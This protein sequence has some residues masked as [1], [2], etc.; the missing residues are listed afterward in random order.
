MSVKKLSLLVMSSLVA[1]GC[2]AIPAK[3]G[4]RSIKQPDGTTVKVSLRG[5]ETNHMYINQAG[6]RMI[7]NADGMLVAASADDLVSIKKKE[8][9]RRAKRNMPIRRAASENTTQVPHVNSPRI[10][11]LL[12]QYSDYKF[13]DAD[14]LTTFRSFFS[15][16]E[17]SAHQYFADQS[18]NKFT[19]QFDVYGPVTLTGKRADY[20]G[21]DSQGYDIGVGKMVGQAC[22]AMD[23]QVDFSLYDNDGDGECDVVIVLYAGDGEASSYD[24]DAEDS[25]WPCQ[26]DLASSEFGKSLKLDGTKVNLFA[27][28]NELYGSD[29]KKIDGIGT[30]C[31]EFS[32]CLGLPDFYDTQYGPHFG[33]AH[34]SLMDYG[35]YN[36]DGFTP[37]G[38][39]A[40]EKDFMGWIEI[41]E[42]KEN[43]FYTLTPMNLK[44]EET[45]MAVRITNNSDKNEYYIL[46][47]RAKQGWDKFMPAEG[48]L[49]THFTYSASAWNNNTVNDYDLQRA[50]IIPADNSLKLDTEVVWGETYYYINDDDVL[51]DLWPQSY[52]TELT[53]TSVP[54][55]KVNTGKFMSK[56]IT[57]IVRNADGTVSFWAMKKP[58]PQVEMPTNLRH[59]IL[60][61]TTV[62]FTWES[63]D[64]NIS[65]YTLE[66]AE[67]VE[68]PYTL[69]DDVDFSNSD[70]TSSGYTAVED[71]ALRFGSNKQQG[72]LTSGVYTTEEDHDNVS[73]VFRAKSYGS[74]ASSV[75]V[76]LLDASSKELATQT[77]EL[78]DA[79]KDYTL[80]F[81]VAGNTKFKVRFE[82]VAL[83]KRFY[84]STAQIYSGDYSDAADT[85]RKKTPLKM[86]F[87]NITDNHYTVTG[88]N[89]E[90]L[91]TYRVM[92]HPLDAETYD[93][94][95]W[96]EKAFID[97]A[98]SVDTVNANV[99]K[100]VRWFTI[101]GEALN[102]K[103]TVPGLYIKV[104]ANRAEKVMIK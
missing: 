20:G 94:S 48:M 66:V 82:T 14:P 43:T 46:E 72:V 56:P 35:C 7:K 21:N 29:L 55:A 36:E 92:A 32:H 76:S 90:G 15:S 61:E 38:Y 18:N 31:H 88:L 85:R 11:V 12:V 40:Y 71:D 70:W 8:Q 99:N 58:L 60:D 4:F 89:P 104:S 9:Q 98:V 57:Q 79:Y 81:N 47:N 74:D 51:T 68:N 77:V 23:S 24:D 10:P 1:I 93:N 19:P 80:K 84:L 34:W 28:F 69:L 86:V 101:S 45:D 27:V 63:N 5:D 83:K 64:E 13:K 37:I 16:G 26:W 102:E 41:P 75:K 50:T 65:H 78:S 97:V 67:Y 103:P 17:K 3:H 25:V 53:D 6:E 44:S 73:V 33:M 42:V 49:I 52:A 54:A 95:A 22:N 91:Y 100:V 87:E 2:Y 39:S 96:T 62:D 30:F 59:S